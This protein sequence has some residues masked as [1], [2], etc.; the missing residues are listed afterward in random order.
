MKKVVT[1]SMVLLTNWVGLTAAEDPVYFPDAELKAAIEQ[2][3]GVVDPTP[4]DMLALTSSFDAS[5]RASRI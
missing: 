4:T 3:L 5:H 1:F 2:A